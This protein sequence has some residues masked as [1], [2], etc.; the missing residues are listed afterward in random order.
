[1][2]VYISYRIKI[3]VEGKKK[4]KDMAG[5]RVRIIRGSRHKESQNRA[6]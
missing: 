1:M 3:H 5:V 4:H 2:K 6:E